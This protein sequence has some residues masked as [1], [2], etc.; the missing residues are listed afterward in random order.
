MTNGK[1]L[2]AGVAMFAARVLK[3]LGVKPGDEC[4]DRRGILQV[5]VPDGYREKHG[6]EWVTVLYSDD[7][8]TAPRVLECEHQALDAVMEYMGVVMEKK[9]EE[10][11]DSKNQ[12]DGVELFVPAPE[13]F[14]FVHVDEEPAEAEVT[15]VDDAAS[16]LSKFTTKGGAA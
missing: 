12:D 3:A 15:S 4:T 2:V 5:R 7:T 1:K 6:A 9:F 14:R 10:A 16:V 11:M 8:H 13:D